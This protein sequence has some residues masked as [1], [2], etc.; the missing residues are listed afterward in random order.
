MAESST[1]KLRIALDAVVYLWLIGLAFYAGI[2]TQRVDDLRD[3]INTR[4][5]VQIS[6]EASNRLTALESN[7]ARIEMRMLEIERQ[8]RNQE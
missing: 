4:G 1:G 8:L 7:A 2:L 5:R 3:A 6:I